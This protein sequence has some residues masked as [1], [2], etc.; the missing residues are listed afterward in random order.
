MIKRPTTP[1]K[2]TKKGRNT[3]TWKLTTLAVEL[4]VNPT[5]LDAH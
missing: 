4:K 5:F 1:P 2:T 3:V